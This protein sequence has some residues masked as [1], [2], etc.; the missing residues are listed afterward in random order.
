MELRAMKLGIICACDTELA[1]FLPHIKDD[2]ITEKAMIN[3][4]S[5]RILNIS[6]TA[7]FCGSCKVNAAAAAQILIDN[8]GVT[9]VINAGTAGGMDD[10]VEI[11]DTIISTQAVYHDVEGAV[12]TEYFPWMPD[13]YFY[14]DKKML[15]A[16]RAVNISRSYPHNIYFGRTVT[17]E[18]FITDDGRDRINAKYSPLS[19][20]METGAIAHVCYMNNIPFIAVRTITDTAKHSGEDNF[21][22]NCKQASEISKSFTLGMID[23]LKRMERER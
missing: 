13:E 9:A 3:F 16:A 21:R 4:H 7:L 17:G 20:D 10:K 1:P 15:E 19:V 14:T 12:L 22:I 5:G 8:F 6:V 2:V 18:V 23:E 11:L